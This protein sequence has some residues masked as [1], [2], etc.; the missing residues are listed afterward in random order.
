LKT[1]KETELFQTD[2]HGHLLPTKQY[3]LLCYFS[4]SKWI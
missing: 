3:L 4:F 1:T 2:Q